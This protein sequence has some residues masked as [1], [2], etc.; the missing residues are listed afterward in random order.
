[1]EDWKWIDDILMWCGED[2]KEIMMTMMEE[3]DKWRTPEAT[4][5]CT[6]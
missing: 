6:N 3:R 2:I 1:M 5:H 4:N